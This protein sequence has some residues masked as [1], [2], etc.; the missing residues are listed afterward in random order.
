MSVKI[1][2]LGCAFIAM[3]CALCLLTHGEIGGGG[4]TKEVEEAPPKE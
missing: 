4:E 3:W 2:P 1:H